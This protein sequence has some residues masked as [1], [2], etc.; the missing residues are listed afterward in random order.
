MSIDNCNWIEMT[1]DYEAPDGTL[2][3]SGSQYRFEG[4]YVKQR[5]YK[6]CEEGC[7]KFIEHF[8]V[9]LNDEWYDIP[10]DAAVIQPDGNTRPQSE[11]GYG[12]RKTYREDKSD[13]MKLSKEMFGAFPDK[14]G[15]DVDVRKYREIIGDKLDRLNKE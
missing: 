4:R 1:D 15:K 2:F 11:E 3:L 14:H 10:S 8:N 12:W 6:P 7:V 5:Y 9:C 13:W